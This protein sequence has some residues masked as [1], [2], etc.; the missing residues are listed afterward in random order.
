MTRTSSSVS[1]PSAAS[2]REA[3]SVGKGCLISLVIVL[4]LVGIAWSMTAGTYNGIV[5]QD[6][7]VSSK[8]TILDSQY[9]RRMDLVPQLV[10]VVKGAADFEKSTLTEITDARAKVG[11]VTLPDAPTDEAEFQRYMQAQQ[12]LG[13]ALSKLL[14]VAENYPTLTATSSFRDLQAQIEGTENRINVARIDYANAVKDYN[15]AI[16]KFPANFVATFGGFEK[17][18]QMESDPTNR[19]VPQID[20][21][22]KK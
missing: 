1:R 21:G 10:E 2:R 14:V 15:V 11:Q 6:E 20:F 22:D 7:N 9:Q 12:Q 8:W 18:A 16:R 17:K 4:V 13:S 5:A 3:G 19:E